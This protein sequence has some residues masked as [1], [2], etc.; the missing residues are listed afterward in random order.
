MLE[1][2]LNSINTDYSRLQPKLRL[3]ISGS[4]YEWY[5]YDIYPRVSTRSSSITRHAES[6]DILSERNH[7]KTKKSLE[8][9]IFCNTHLNKFLTLTFRD[10]VTDVTQANDLFQTFIKRLR[11]QYSKFQYIAVP[12]RQHRGAIHYHILCSLPFVPVIQIAKMWSH[13]FVSIRRVD[14][15][16]NLARY[17]SKYLGK[18]L[19]DVSMKGKKKFFCSAEL[20][21]PMVLY[22]EDAQ[23]RI[24]SCILNKIFQKDI[25]IFTGTMRYIRYEDVFLSHTM[26][27]V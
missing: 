18:D 13:G 23:Q 6:P 9:L 5:E 22:D 25:S 20:A 19:F 21:R 1:H 3:V 14:R 27:T 17:V 26:A 24:S 15:T 10:N 7:L 2:Q 12:E 11:R 16:T 8:R 4:L